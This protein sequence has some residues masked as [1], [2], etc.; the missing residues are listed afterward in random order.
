MRLT[1]FDHLIKL[2]AKPKLRNTSDVK[3]TNLLR[4]LNTRNPSGI[5]LVCYLPPHHQSRSTRVMFEVRLCA[6]RLLA[7]CVTQILTPCCHPWATSL[8]CTFTV[9]VFQ[10][11]NR[12]SPSV[13]LE[14][15]FPSASPPIPT[16]DGQFSYTITSLGH[17]SILP[18]DRTGP[19][20]LLWWKPT[21]QRTDLDRLHYLWS[22]LNCCWPQ[23]QP[24]CSQHPQLG[25]QDGVSAMW[26]GTRYH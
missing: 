11:E 18:A 17:S 9:M 15:S 25:F 16:L 10:F 8:C 23:L 14:L 22:L 6:T 4:D 24:V 3:F 26:P 5:C 2:P 20:L 12:H 13:L 19:S 7:H 21:V 1:F